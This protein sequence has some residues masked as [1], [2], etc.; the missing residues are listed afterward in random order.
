MIVLY[1]PLSTTPGKQP[2]PLSLMALAAMLEGRE[3]WKLVDANVMSELAPERS[4][5]DREVAAA[6]V[7][8]LTRAPRDEGRLLAVTVMPGPQLSQA[9]PVCRA[10]RQLLPEVPIVWGG[11]F[12]TG[13]TETVLRAPY[14]DFVVR[15]QGERSLLDL[16]DALRNGGP[17]SKVGGLSWKDAGGRV[18]HNPIQAPTPLDELPDLPYRRVPMQH[19]LHPTYLGRR[20]VAHNS[21]FGCPFSCNFCAVVAMSNRRWL[22]QS[23]AR[24]ERVVRRLVADYGADAVMMHDMDFFISEARVAEFA[25]RIAGLGVS[26]WGLGRIDTLM[27]YSDATWRSMARSGLRMVFSG[28]ESASDE[29]LRAMN[30]GGTSSAKLALDLAR[31]MRGFGVV[32]EYSFVLGLPPNP[33]EDV[34]RTF[35]FIRRI[36]RVNPATEIVLYT[37]TPVPMDGALY[38][39]AQTLG[40]RFPDTLEEW[41]SDEWRQ[42]MMRRG[43]HIPWVDGS[44]RRH[45]RNF[46]RVLNAFYPTVTDARLTPRRRALLRAVSALR[47]KWKLYGAP[48]ELRVLHR[49]IQYQRP[50][51][52]GF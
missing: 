36:K 1:N 32:P 51:T 24:L 50:E 47:Y 48:Y 19:Y 30:K 4:V 26:W 9:V 28:A 2:L 12:P 43:E 33:L 52:T 5:P 18:V 25:E 31:R 13:H 45:V 34:E 22:A 37:Y 40:F 11:Y 23:P 27:R 10:V 39:G 35:E 20:T 21:S 29:T 8:E 15:S 49:L 14:V 6:L 3:A 16:V 41:A 7:A 42:L 38:A 46:E 44:V 17:L